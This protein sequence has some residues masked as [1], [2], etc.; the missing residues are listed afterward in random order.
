M[1]HFKEGHI[2]VETVARKGRMHFYLSHLEDFAFP[3]IRRPQIVL[4]Q[5]DRVLRRTE[6]VCLGKSK[7]KIDG[8][9]QQINVEPLFVA[10]L[11]AMGGG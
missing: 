6:P 5:S 9:D 4:A 2:V 1:I 11:S 10:V 7:M 8:F 3:G